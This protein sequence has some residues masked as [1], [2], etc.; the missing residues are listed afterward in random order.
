[1]ATLLDNAVLVGKETTYGTAASL[2]RSFEAQS[3]TFKRTQEALESIG[4]R[5]GMETKRADRRRMID[6]GGTGTIEADVLD[7]GFGLLLEA[8]LG[9]DSGPTQ[10]G[11]TTAYKS[12]FT[13]TTADPQIS[14]TVQTQRV[15]LE[16]TVNSFTHLGSV[17]TGWEL[18]Q[19]VG[20]N[21]KLVLNFDFRT[22]VTNEAAGTNSYPDGVPFDWTMASATWGGAS[23]CPASFSLSADLGL[24]TDRRLLCG[25]ELKKQPVRAAVPMFTGSFDVEFENNDFYDDFVAGSTEELVITWTGAA[26]DTENAQVVVTLPAVQLDGDTPEVSVSDIPTQSLPFTVLDNGTDPAVTIEY[27]TTDTAL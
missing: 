2:T 1:M 5:G 22:V 13:T 11:A 18:S 23:F 24:K 3:D 15:D 14:Y 16:G 20:E 25:T 9:A 19:A 12:T 27:T 6:M 8:S 7:S 21:L 17:I 10:V 4:F 26:I